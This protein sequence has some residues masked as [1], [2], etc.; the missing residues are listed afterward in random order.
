MSFKVNFVAGGIV[1]AIEAKV[2]NE[3]NKCDY[4][5]WVQLNLINVEAIETLTK[6]NPN[7]MRILLFIMK[8][9]DGYNA[10]VCSQQVIQD[11]LG[12]SRSTVA[13]A[14]RLLKNL[15]YIKICKAGSTN[16]YHLNSEIA[17]KSWST[18]KQYAEFSARVLVSETEQDKQ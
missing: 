3:E 14:I 18:N 15:N 8:E 12:L 13:R 7:A 17:W 6:E 4:K 2:R 11:A 9:M 16:V 10:L 5:E 1:M